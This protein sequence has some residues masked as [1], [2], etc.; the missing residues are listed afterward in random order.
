MIGYGEFRPA[1]SDLDRIDADP[2]VRVAASGSF[3]DAEPGS[4]DQ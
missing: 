1:L 2:R 3:L 4:A